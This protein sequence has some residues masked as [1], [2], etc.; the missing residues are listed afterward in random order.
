MKIA[1]LA[2]GVGA[3]IAS[4]ITCVSA[5]GK[6]E[7]TQRQY[8]ELSA[9]IDS[10]FAAADARDL[11]SI[12]AQIK[13][14]VLQPDEDHEEWR[15][16]KLTLWLRMLAKAHSASDR[17]S[18]PDDKP[19]RNIAPRSTSEVVYDSGIDPSAIKDPKVREE[20]EQRLAENA[21]KAQ[22]ARFHSELQR[23]Q[24]GWTAQLK[25]HVSSQYSA[26]REDVAEIDA[27]LSQDVSDDEFR[28]R[29]RASLLKVL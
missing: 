6:S 13:A 5:Q 17:N 24:V 22:T 7:A 12:E 29:L 16:D 1:V 4:L 8:R 28:S 19:S 21:R 18:A 3:V 9:K 27:L 25:S 15:R 11:A 14:F 26:S 23:L 10:A 20:Y 2:F